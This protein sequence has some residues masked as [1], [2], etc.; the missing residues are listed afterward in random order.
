MPL[1]A[2][3]VCS[4][5]EGQIKLNRTGMLS[6]HNTAIAHRYVLRGIGGLPGGI[7]AGPPIQ[8]ERGLPG[9][10]LIEGNRIAMGAREWSDGS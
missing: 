10:G 2:C 4:S 6:A 7:S 5:R 3:S 1:S 9:F 8:I